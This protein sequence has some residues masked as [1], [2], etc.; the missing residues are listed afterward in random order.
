MQSSNLDHTY[1]LPLVDGD[2]LFIDNSTLERFVTCPRSAGYYVG[3]RRE[4]DKSRAALDFGKIIHEALAVRYARFPGYVSNECVSA[5]VAEIDRGFTTYHPDPDEF[6]NYGV[7]ISA[8]QH[9]NST[10]PMEEFE[11]VQYNGK[12]FVEQPF[13]IPLGEIEVNAVLWVRDPA[14]NLITQ[15]HVKTLKIVWKGRIDL[16]YQREGFLY[17]M[18]HKTTSIMGPQFFAEFE[19]SHQV[20]GY[21]WAI[22]KLL[23]SLPRGFVINGLGIRKPTKTGKSLEFVRS[24]IPIYDSLVNEWEVDTLHIVSDFVEMCRRAYLPKHTKWCVGKYGACEYKQVCGLEPSMRATAIASN[25][26]RDVT[27]DPL[28]NE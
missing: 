18:D 26:Y 11:V 28:K 6:R 13:A 20:H 14:T 21:S 19:L 5:M 16:V 15:R 12:P 10:Y 23:G 7:A 22:K 25:E 4:L 9:Y 27:W 8:V 17:G 3:L 2:T 1:A 24:T